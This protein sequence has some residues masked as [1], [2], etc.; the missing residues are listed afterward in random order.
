MEVLPL[1]KV[2]LNWQV[3]KRQFILNLEKENK[4]RRKRFI[5]SFEIFQTDVEKIEPTIIWAYNV[6]AFTILYLA[7]VT[8]ANYPSDYLFYPNMKKTQNRICL[9]AQVFHSNSLPLFLFSHL[10]L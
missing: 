7:S 6:L 4:K 9:N 1:K 8:T 3:Q 10:I 5:T 2:T